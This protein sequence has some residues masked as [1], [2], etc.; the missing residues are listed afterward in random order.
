MFTYAFYL[1][2][3]Q[4]LEQVCNYL[5]GQRFDPQLLAVCMY[6]EVSLGKTPNP[7]SLLMCVHECVRV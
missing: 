3:P 6:V 5:E 4:N 1:F 7:K 2:S